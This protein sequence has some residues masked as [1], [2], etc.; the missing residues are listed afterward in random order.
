MSTLLY[1]DDEALIR[2]TLAEF[3]RH[4]D[5]NVVRLTEGSE[6]VIVLRRHRQ[7]TAINRYIAM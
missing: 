7:I 6:V 1:V 2:D 5:P 3:L 4:F